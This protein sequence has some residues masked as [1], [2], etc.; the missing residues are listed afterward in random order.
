MAV[1][2]FLIL[3]PGRKLETR[4]MATLKIRILTINIGF[5]YNY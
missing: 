4:K 2:K 5:P 3:I 1:I